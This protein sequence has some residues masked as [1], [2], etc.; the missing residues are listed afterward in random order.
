NN[1]GPRL[2]IA[3]TPGTTNRT[4]VRAG[5]GIFYGR[6]P[7]I[8]IGT[9]M[10]NNGINVQTITFTGNL[11]PTY[12]SIYSSLPTGATLPKPTIFVFDPNF[13]NP[14]V[15]QSSLGVEQQL[16]SDFSVGATYQFV[17]GDDL[18][19]SRDVNVST[20][21]T[22]TATIAGGGTVDFTRYTGRPFSNF[23][24]VI[25][26][27]ST[28]RS[29]YNGVTLDLQ[30]R[31]ANNWQ[32]RIAWTHS[33]VK[34]N[35]PDATAVVPFSS[36]D[37]S[38]YA[39]DPLNLERDYT[40]GDNDVRDRIVLSGVWAVGNY[41]DDLQTGF[42]KALATG[43]TISGI[44]S[45][46]TGQ[47]FTPVV[48][49]DLNNDGNPSNDLAPGFRRNSQRLP[50]QFS[51]DP[52]ITRDI[53]LLSGVRLTLIGEAFNITNRH[54]VNNLNRALYSYATATQTLTRISNYEFP[55]STA[56]QRV[57]QLAGKVTF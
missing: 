39:S 51:I 47:P 23:T 19:R 41:A 10:S 5:Y 31:F 22:V 50:S 3:W 36:G 48:N 32:G 6:T 8:M 15:Q 37:D 2:G 57:V 14:K 33:T 26:F 55:T 56:G 12:P 49:S 16:G 11:I 38:K 28:A 4:V 7:S 42:L 40:F 46:Q 34:D 45:Y 18:P 21:T 24:R 44:V 25:A 53:P 35:K 13:Q 1:I 52:R 17:K 29:Q 9:G 20:P 30:K 27:E 54:N 43:W